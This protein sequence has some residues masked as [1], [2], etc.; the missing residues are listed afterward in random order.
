MEYKNIPSGENIPENIYAIIEISSQSTPVKYE[1][2]KKTGILFVD[3]FIPTPLFYPCNYGYINNT[4]SED[5]DPL[6]VLVVSPYPLQPKSVILCNPIGI[7]N[8][9]DESGKDPKIIAIPNKKISKIYKNIKN[10]TDLPKI[11]KNQIQFFFKNYK[12]LEKKKWVKIKNWGGV[13]EAKKEI[14]NSI[15]RKKIGK[16]YV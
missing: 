2:N 9:E 6:D 13:K 4:L 5:K 12:K 3:R 16:L 1:I 10:I 8:M 7:L 15:K 14:L 11:I